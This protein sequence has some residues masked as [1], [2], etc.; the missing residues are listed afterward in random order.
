MPSVTYTLKVPIEHLKCPHCGI[1]HVD[2]N[3]WALKPHKTHLCTQCGG[4]FEGSIHA[5]SHPM[6]QPAYA[7]KFSAYTRHRRVKPLYVW[8]LTMSAA[9]VATA[10]GVWCLANNQITA[11]WLLAAS[12]AVISGIGGF[13]QARNDRL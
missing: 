10:I 6:V 8:L 1:Q 13:K 7:A 12:G 4:L 5:V 2:E 11:G 3:E 9:S